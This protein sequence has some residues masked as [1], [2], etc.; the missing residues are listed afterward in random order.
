M[1]KTIEN[2]R[3]GKVISTSSANI[4]DSLNVTGN[5]SGNTEDVVNAGGDAESSSSDEEMQTEMS[6]YKYSHPFVVTALQLTN[7]ITEETTNFRRTMNMCML[8]GDDEESSGSGRAVV[9]PSSSRTRGAT[10]FNTMLKRFHRIQSGNNIKSTCNRMDLIPFSS[11]SSSF[12]TSIGQP[13]TITESMVTDTVTG[14]AA[15]TGV[16]VGPCT[17]TAHTSSLSATMKLDAAGPNTI[18]PMESMIVADQEVNNNNNRHSITK[19]TPNM[20]IDSIMGD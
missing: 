12:E 16:S 15:A 3:S 8:E 14:I 11:P 19:E 5:E 13:V 1:L 20:S 6:D 2:K 17:S 7:E 10:S 4:G 18:T 9:R